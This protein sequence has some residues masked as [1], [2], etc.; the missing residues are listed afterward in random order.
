VR[1]KLK[2][3]VDVFWGTSESASFGEV[4]NDRSTPRVV[5]TILR[6]KVL[7]PPRSWNLAFEMGNREAWIGRL[8]LAAVVSVAGA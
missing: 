3:A 5:K 6:Q 7:Q 4:R 2:H 8:G 1:E